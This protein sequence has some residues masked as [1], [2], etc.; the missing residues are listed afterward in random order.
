MAAYCLITIVTTSKTIGHYAK[1]AEQEKTILIFSKNNV[2]I[3]LAITQNESVKG[4]VLKLIHNDKEEKMVLVTKSGKRLRETEKLV[5][6][7]DPQA[8]F[9]ALE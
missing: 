3:Q 4:D 5:Y 2:E 1:Q 8:H 9:L 6:K 7:T